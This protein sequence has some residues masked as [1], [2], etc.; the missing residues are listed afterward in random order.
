MCSKLKDL[1]VNYLPE[2]RVICLSHRP[3]V[4]ADQHQKLATSFIRGLLGFYA[5]IWMREGADVLTLA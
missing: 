1:G 4:Q 2:A 3:L 5:T